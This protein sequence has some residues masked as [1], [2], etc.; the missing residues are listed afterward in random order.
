MPELDPL[1]AGRDGAQLAQGG[2][3]PDQ[4][5]KAKKKD[6]V[7]SVWISFI[8]RI[9]AQII[10]AVAK[11]SSLDRGML[12]LPVALAVAAVLWLALARLMR[13]SAARP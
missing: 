11:N 6:R 12:I 5:G 9:V 10:G 1:D 4:A 13:K 8:G 2:D 3:G 7:R